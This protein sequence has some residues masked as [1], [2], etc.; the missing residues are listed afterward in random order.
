MVCPLCVRD[1]ARR[2]ENQLVIS[3]R[4]LLIRACSLHGPQGLSLLTPQTLNKVGEPAHAVL[5]ML[6]TMLRADDS[7]LPSIATGR[8]LAHGH[9]SSILAKLC[10][11]FSA[12]NGRIAANAAVN[13]KGL[14]Q[15]MPEPCC[16]LFSDF[17]S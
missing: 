16:R 5:S 14:M 11:F 1:E 3:G 17:F 4:P 15:H 2:G 12:L 10:T 7:N 8:E 13:T 6:G 9:A